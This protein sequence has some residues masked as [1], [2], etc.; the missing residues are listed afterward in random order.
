M[1]SKIIK[2]MIVAAVLAV[3]IQSLPDMKRYLELREM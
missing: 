2:A 1:I 3:I